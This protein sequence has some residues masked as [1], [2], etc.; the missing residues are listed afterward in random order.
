MIQS[1]LT[2]IKKV[3]NLAA[4]DP[5]FDEDVL[6][7]INS[8]FSDLNQLGIGPEEGFEITDN[9]ATWDSFLDGPLQSSV[10]SYM[11]LRVRMIFDPPVN[12]AV[13]D[14]MEKQA[15]RFEFRLNVEREGRL[16][17]DPTIQTV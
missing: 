7:H 2:S 17:Q 15:E 16:W 1:I 10:K 4:D 11:Y 3:V 5:S 8:V 9:T 6:M 12:K 14:S 13:M